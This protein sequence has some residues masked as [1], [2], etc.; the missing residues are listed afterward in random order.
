MTAESKKITCGRWLSV[1]LEGTL[2]LLLSTLMFP[3]IANA[4]G[5]TQLQS[6]SISTSSENASP[7]F[8]KAS[9]D[10]YN[11]AGITDDGYLYMWGWNSKHE[12]LTKDTNP[13]ITP[14]RIMGNV[15][16]VILNDEAIHAI[17]EDGRLWCWAKEQS[18][19]DEKISPNLVMK[20]VKQAAYDKDRYIVLKED[21]SVWVWG[22]DL[23]LDDVLF[24]Y[25]DEDD[26][27]YYRNS[28]KPKKIASDAICVAGCATNYAYVK[29]NG[30]LY[31][32]GDNFNGQ[33]GDGST[34]AVSEPKK[35][36]SGVKKVSMT[37]CCSIAVLKND[38]SVWT[39]GNNYCGQI[40]NGDTDKEKDDV[41]IPYKVLD[42]AQDV[43]IGGS[44]CAAIKEN[45]DLWTWGEISPDGSSVPQLTLEGVSCA[46]VEDEVSIAVTKSGELKT[47]G[48]NEIGLLGTTKY[49]GPFDSE[50]IILKDVEYV[51]CG[52]VSGLAI[53]KDG[54]LYGWGT[55]GEQP[56]LSPR[57]VAE[58]VVSACVKSGADDWFYVTSDGGLWYVCT[59][60]LSPM[61]I[62][63]GI[64]S[65][66]GGNGLVVV[67]NEGELLVEKDNGIGAEYRDKVSF[68]C[69]DAAT[70][71]GYDYDT[72]ESF[73]R[74]L[75]DVKDS[76][77][78]VGYGAAIKND[79]TLWTW[80]YNHFG[81]LGIGEDSEDGWHGPKQVLSNVESVALGGDCNCSY[82]TSLALKTDGTVWGWGYDGHG[83]LEDGVSK[84]TKIASNAKRIEAGCYCRLSYIDKNGICFENGVNYDSY[85]EL[86]GS[87]EKTSS[88]TI[89]IAYGNCF[90]CRLDTSGNLWSVGESNWAGRLGNGK[91]SECRT[92][93]TVPVKAVSGPLKTSCQTFKTIKKTWT[94]KKL[95]VKVTEKP[96][97][98]IKGVTSA[99]NVGIYSFELIPSKGYVWSDGSTD[100]K[101][102]TWK[103]LP[104]RITIKSIKGGERSLIVKWK[105]NKRMS[106]YQVRFSTDVSMKKAKTKTIRSPKRA[107]LKVGK[108]KKGKTYYV[109]VRVYK[110]VGN[111]K[112]CSVWSGRK[113]VTVR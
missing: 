2:V 29:K 91:L 38:G 92:P 9:V 95:S 3:A 15:Q 46:S 68:S 59:S 71:G 74:I 50:T 83:M 11:A 67:T 112:I 21:G 54:S 107:S 1:F 8:V 58:D 63:E 90:K 113:K 103:I 96:G 82:P 89:Q 26:H 70:N 64:K 62:A 24:L 106:G 7:R 10:Y 73:Y 97:Y 84:P 35:V 14:T 6:A 75:T 98:M 102:V 61:K 43:E 5:V 13:R 105:K 51:D 108:L 55:I 32:W 4:E 85:T 88:D 42:G 109:Q 40:G 104:R 12:L 25:D 65:V 53:L 34:K 66:S 30:D 48:H 69:P 20:N 19:G 37:S 87:F 33:I 110:K 49:S 45:G 16:D 47:W 101:S 56:L 100:A 99:K 94:G 86:V 27:V 17:T 80:G 41:S 76:A 81:C 93:E 78:G 72:G 31:I 77:S 79:G 18:F 57:K 60:D 39:W 22:E 44:G 28:K 111:R 23:K 36:M 52:D